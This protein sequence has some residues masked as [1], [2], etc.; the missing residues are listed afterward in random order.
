MACPA[1]RPRDEP[2][3]ADTPAPRPHT[4]SKPLRKPGIA[5]SPTARS[6]DHDA[7]Q[8]LQSAQSIERALSRFGW[9]GDAD[10]VLAKLGID[11]TGLRAVENDDEVTAALE[12]RK[13]A[14]VN[15]PWR[16]EHPQARTRRFFEDAL[17][18]HIQTVLHAAWKAVPYGY[19]VFEVVYAEP[20]DPLNTT[21]GRIG[22]AGVIEC[23]FEWFRL[24]PG[25]QLLWREAN[26]AADPRKFMATVRG[27]SLR[28]PAGDA[29]LAKAY[30]P[31]YF[32]THGWR[33]WAKFME[34]AAIP[35]I[36]GKTHGDQAY[37]LQKLSQISSGPVI[38]LGDG[39]DIAGLDIGSS[40]ANKFTEFELACCRRI[41]RLILGQTLTSGTDGG[42]G[43]RALGEVHNDVRK[44]K[45]RTDILLVQTSI[46]R[47]C[48]TLAALNGIVDV[49][50]FIMEDE[51]GL[52]LERAQR[53]KQLADAGILRFTR[54]YLREKYGLEDSDFEVPEPA[55]AQNPWPAALATRTPLTLAP[56]ATRFTAGQ[57]AIEDEIT[58]TLGA[59]ASPIEVSAIASAIRGA[60]SPE[61]LIE[62]LGIALA[63]ADD[64]AFR[65]ALERALFAA[66]LTGYGQAAKASG[67]QR[68]QAGTSGQ[69]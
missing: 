15:T 33:F 6:A 14:C 22:L 44:E 66:D 13:A 3:P 60:N 41:Q 24:Q 57:Q 58:R 49:P 12:T 63:G 35:L 52:E 43:N 31:W 59:I 53:D 8:A 42:S 46:Q 39:D 47:L 11:R 67:N 29:L 40:N 64:R 2:V 56:P 7:P 28:K 45:T 30:W 23:P 50:Q 55:S 20:S 4:P 51:S 25:G 5:R 16:I 48:D 27:A 69:T 1:C 32:R 54:E 17:R 38:A 36:Y 37:M 18:P 62:R 34:Q 68:E 61:D 21:P 9:L 10:E 19:S 65:H 26:Q